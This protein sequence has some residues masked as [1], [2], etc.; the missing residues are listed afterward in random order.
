[1]SVAIP[2]CT[3]CLQGLCRKHPM[4]D[5]GERAAKLKSESQGIIK[6]SLKKTYNELIKSQ[7]EKLDPAALRADNKDNIEYKEQ[8]ELDRLNAESRKR[9]SLSNDQLYL[10]KNSTLHASVLSIMMEDS[11]KETNSSTSTFQSSHDDQNDDNEQ[12]NKKRKKEE[13]DKKEKKLKKEKKSKKK[14]HKKHKKEK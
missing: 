12:K 1:M 6:D 11:D 9:K 10:A 13:K 8:L 14:K 3:N 5:H 2:R 4:Q 7:I